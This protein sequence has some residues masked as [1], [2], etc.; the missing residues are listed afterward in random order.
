MGSEKGG[1][2]RELWGGHTRLRCDYAVMR[3]VLD[4]L[5]LNE[6]GG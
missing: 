3:S 4:L 5:T 1:K 6:P 2:E